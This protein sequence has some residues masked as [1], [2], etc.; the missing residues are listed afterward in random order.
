MPDSPTTV[1]ADPGGDRDEALRSVLAA[2]RTGTWRWDAATG[3]VHWDETLE[4]LNG[5][6]PGGFGR[7]WEA[8][9]ATL[10]PD[11]VAGIVEQVEAAVAARGPYHF[12][13]RAMWPD[14]QER[15]VECRGQVTTDADGEVTGTV[16]CVF[17]VTE[18]KELDHQREVT[19]LEERVVRDRIEFLGALTASAAVADDHDAFMRAACDAAVP[20]LGDWCSMHFIPEPSATAARVVAHADPEKLAWARALIAR[21]PYDPEAETGVA[22]VIRSGVTEFVPE[23]T[24]ELV[25]E[26]ITRSDMPEAEAR[27]V[28]DQ[29]GVT[30]VITV[31]MATKRGV[32]G[33]MQFV[34]A[35]SGRIYGKDDVALAEVAA[36]RIAD[37]LDNMWLLDQHRSISSTLQ[38]ALLPPELPVIDGVEVAAAYSPA[39]SAVEAGGDFYD[40]FEGSPGRW[41]L[42]V[43]DVCGTGADAAAVTGIVRHTVRAAARHDQDHRTVLEWTNEALLHSNRDRFSTA[44]YATLERAVD[45][46]WVLRSAA[47]GH[48]LPVL[49]RDGHPQLLGAPGSLLGIFDEL[50]L[51]VAE[52]VL[53]PGDVL[54]LYTDGITDLPPP[55]DLRADEAGA[56][57]ADCADRGSAAEV[58]AAI[59]L[60]VLAKVPQDRREDDV[61]L[62]VLRIGAA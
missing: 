45:G 21:R 31:P 38:R 20:G 9:L 13:H 34:S 49:V 52:T 25:D 19:L 40:V 58:A 11:E 3:I 18:R 41:S 24:A 27:A 48:P 60:A 5:L 43:G 14:G 32:V 36:S 39:G 54:V 62:L 12:E 50:D 56:L 29:L 33:A 23:V 53:R 15:W 59:E 1:D 46:T 7:T 16:G 44:V 55:D 26:A 57:F 8:W 61:A 47:A 51:S 10:H 4:A 37:V 28:L 6:A 35:E 42:V 30:S 2:A 22:A 17:D